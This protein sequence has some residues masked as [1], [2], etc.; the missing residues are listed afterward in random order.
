MFETNAYVGTIDWSSNAG[1]YYSN[2]SPGGILLGIPPYYLAYQLESFLALSPDQPQIAYF[3]AYLI[4][5]FVSVIPFAFSAMAFYALL[6]SWGQ[7][8]KRALALTL[9]YIFATPFIAYNQT[10]WGTN[11]LTSFL[12][13]SLYYLRREAS[14][15]ILAGIFLGLALQMDY[16]AFIAVGTILLWLILEQGKKSLPTIISYS[17]VVGLMLIYQY[18]CFGSIFKSTKSN[19]N[20]AF[21][22]PD[23]ILG[24]FSTPSFSVIWSLLFSLQK[25]M[26]L[27][28]PIFLFTIIGLY[29]WLK[30]NPRDTLLWISVVNIIA[31]L[32]FISTF[33]GWHG[34]ATTFPRYLIPCLIFWLIP[35]KECL[36]QFKWPVFLLATF[37]AFNSLVL[38]AISPISPDLH[39]NP[40]YD[41]S[42][43]LFFSGK[44]APIKYPIRLQGLDPNFANYQNL[45]SGNIGQLL[46]L[47]G[48]TSLIP[49]LLIIGL[50]A[51]ILYKRLNV[52]N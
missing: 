32:M 5:F 41:F 44:L 6:Q 27:F 26:I 30:R 10:M 49:L 19:G 52:E 29:Y 15:P 28:M 42:Y 45:S 46:G 33:N 22:N 50:I 48:I 18:H 24:F 7:A 9:I 31:Y 8:K 51:F 20:P 43:K 16:L 36:V 35:L 37:S 12:V 14:R 39:P 47:S 2:K 23:L 25:G 1:H 3:N 40:L 34:G 11:T 4:N 13:I 21:E 17:V 38:S